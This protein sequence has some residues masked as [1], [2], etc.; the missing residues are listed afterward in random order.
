V[1]RA[2]NPRAQN[3]PGEVDIVQ[4]ATLDHEVQGVIS[5]IQGLIA[6][7]TPPGDILVLAQRS[8]IGTPI[9]EA[10][11]A[12]K[13][14]TRSYYAE[15]ELDAE[16]AQARFAMLKLYVDREDYVGLRWLLGFGSNDWRT[17]SYQRLRAHCESDGTSPWQALEQL[18]SGIIAIPY[19][20]PLIDQ[21]KQIRAE[22]ERL[23]ALPDL[24]SVIDDLLPNGN[25]SV[26]DLR[27]LALQTL[28]TIGE[29]R[30]QF[31]TE[32]TTSITKPEVPTQVNDVRIMSL[33]KSKGLSSP[34]TIIAGCVQGLLP[35]LPD[36]DI[37]A[38][39]QRA[40][41]EEQRRLLYVGIT[42]VKAVPAEG[43]TG[44]LV[45]T[46][47]RQMRVADAMKAR[48]QPARTRYGNAHLIASQFISELG[49][50]APAPR[51]G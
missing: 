29:A 37:P 23:E 30:D 51:R 32:L 33:H 13:V 17:K 3:G 5:I 39:A 24:A 42:R 46:Y 27:A 14:P 34:V 16:E 44:K 6:T 38:A 12:G 41:M 9:Y 45:L 15:S 28:E 8:V 48:I 36:T 49:P 43:K 35:R 20:S 26:R 10:L 1:P 11:V 21:F 47:S 25:D 31:L 19:T 50:S 22:I 2:L 40:Q 4:H 7:G 18:D